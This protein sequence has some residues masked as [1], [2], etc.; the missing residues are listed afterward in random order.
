MGLKSKTTALHAYLTFFQLISLPSVRISMKGN[1]LVIL[2]CKSSLW[3][4]Y[5]S[6]ALVENVM[7]IVMNTSLLSCGALFLGA[8]LPR[9]GKGPQVT[10]LF[11]DSLF[12]F[13]CP[14][15]ARDK[16]TKS[17]VACEQAF[18]YGQAKRAS[19]ERASEG[20]LRRSLVRSRETRFTRPNKRACSQTKSAGDLLNARG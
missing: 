3:L 12:S 11:T 4:Y 15:S 13:Q 17:A 8:R 16:K 10:S 2:L 1:Y 5:F 9:S 19:R 20:P 14:S 6:P 18:L 7:I